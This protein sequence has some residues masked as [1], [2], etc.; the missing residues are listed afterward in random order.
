[1]Y[2]INAL[3]YILECKT[4]RRGKLHPENY[5]IAT[6]FPSGQLYES[7]AYHVNSNAATVRGKLDSARIE[8]G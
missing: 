8:S 6:S 3:L 4:H 5:A 7:Q 1:M 2:R